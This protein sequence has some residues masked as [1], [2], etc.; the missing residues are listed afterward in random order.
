M[1]HVLLV[2]AT[3]VIS[4]SAFAGPGG[5]VRE[6]KKCWVNV[7]TQRGFGFWDRCADPQVRATL[8]RRQGIEETLDRPRSSFGGEDTTTSGGGGGGGG[9]G[10]R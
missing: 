7:D 1:K 9:G 10:G 5:P 3:V 4:T 2:F 6:G 8:N